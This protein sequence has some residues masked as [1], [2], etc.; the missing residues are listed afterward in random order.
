MSALCASSIYTAR[1]AYKKEIKCA[2]L[3]KNTS[4]IQNRL[5]A[6]SH[7]AKPLLICFEVFVFSLNKR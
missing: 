6:V 7:N 1:G 4:I 3:C 5:K 2:K